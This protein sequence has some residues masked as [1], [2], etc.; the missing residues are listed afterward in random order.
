MNQAGADCVQAVLED[1]GKRKLVPALREK[2]TPAPAA[3]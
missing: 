3:P 1:V 2:L